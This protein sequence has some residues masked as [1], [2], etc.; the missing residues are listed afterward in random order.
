MLRIPKSCA[1]N[2]FK[3]PVTY[4]TYGG[5]GGGGGYYS[6]INDLVFIK[7]FEKDYK[8]FIIKFF[9]L[10]QEV[11]PIFKLLNSTV[12]NMFKLIK[13]RFALFFV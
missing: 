7:S 10:E 3:A 5:G 2:V 6:V 8:Y 9:G 4:V 12:I 13:K 1:F 11:F